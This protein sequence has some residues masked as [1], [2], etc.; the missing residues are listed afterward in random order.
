MAISEFYLDAASGGADTNAGTGTGA[1]TILETNGD[2]GNLAA[3]RYTATSGLPFASVN[4]GDWASVYVDGASTAV[5]IAKVTTVGAGGLYVN[6]SA[7]N[8]MG[9][10][11]S[12]SP[13]GRSIKF[14]GAW[15]SL[16][17][18]NSL[19]ASVA[20]AL[21]TR[22]NIKYNASAYALTTTNLALGSSGVTAAPFMV[23]GYNTTISDIDTDNTLA[24]PTI[25]HTTGQFLVTGSY[26]NFFNLIITGA[27]ITNG[28]VRTATGSRIWFH[29]C[30]IEC[31]SANSLGR[32][33]SAGGASST[34]TNCYL[35]STSS[36]DIATPSSLGTF[37][38]CTFDGGKHGIANASGTSVV[39]AGNRFINQTSDGINSSAAN[40]VWWVLLNTFYNPTGS[41]FEQTVDP[42]TSSWIFWGN[43]FSESGDYDINSSVGTVTSNIIRLFNLSH[44]PFTA[45]ENGI[46]DLPA[47][48]AQ[49]DS[50]SPFSNAAGGLFDIVSTSNAKGKG[51][52]GVAF[53][54]QTD[55]SYLDIGAVQR[56]EAAAGG[57]N[58]AAL[59]SGVSAMG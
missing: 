54:N 50:S 57:V 41:G 16:A 19:F 48:G 38:G 53:E 30:R 59:P 58:R 32:A 6:L 25:S 29:Q 20:V 37:I 47:I 51:L 46:S 52:G 18:L 17:V 42:T 26:T 8:K 40:N 24:K 56:V 7:V 49:I 11:P 28:Q 35:K 1:H 45:A 34:F 21:P 36:A 3:N 31:T 13:T 12:V 23:R 10:A 33:V 43:I 22:I 5:Y 39:I 2:W 15:T 9:T 27:Q 55:V 14:G 44:A 4:V